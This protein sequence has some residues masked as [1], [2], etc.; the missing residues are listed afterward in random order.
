MAVYKSQ[1]R[2]PGSQYSCSAT[3]LQFGLKGDVELV[4]RY[5]SFGVIES[6]HNFPWV[7]G[8]S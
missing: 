6:K 8:V 3:I 4:D 7:P 2:G 1:M 5:K